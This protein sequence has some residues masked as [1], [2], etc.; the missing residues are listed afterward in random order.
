MAKERIKY[1]DYLRIICALGVV[2]GHVCDDY[3]SAISVSSASWRVLSAFLGLCY[4]TVPVFFMI[5]GALFL[6]PK[7]EIGV[8]VLYKKYILR[9]AIVF[10]FWS[11]LYAI[12]SRTSSIVAFFGKVL[13]GHYH[14]WFILALLG[15]YMVLPFLRKI[16]ESDFLTKY[17]LGLGL[18][19][20]IFTGYVLPRLEEVPVGVI[21]VAAA[22]ADTFLSAFSVK[23]VLGYPFYVVLGYYLC[24]KDFSKKIWCSLIGVGVVAY[25]V[26]VLITISVSVSTGS[27][28]NKLFKKFSPPVFLM[29]VGLFVLGKYVLSKISLKG[30]ADR[31]VQNLSKYTFGVYLIHVFVLDFVERQL[32]LTA[33]SFN[34]VIAVPCITLIV[35]FV[36]MIIS[37]VLNKIPI[38]NKYIV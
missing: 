15:C 10:F 2:M 35:Y 32:G 3:W 26:M 1:F 11:V 12:A 21:S 33:M 29:A 16:A 37:T 5:S 25:I 18:V 38:V 8:K 27:A 24:K 6:N 17:F 14:M 34:P 7:K 31:F 22:K 23:M 28:Y 20:L 9:M 13:T 30:K 19:F 4:C 36:S